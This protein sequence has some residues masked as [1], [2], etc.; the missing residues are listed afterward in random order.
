MTSPCDDS[1]RQQNGNQRKTHDPDHS[2]TVT[3]GP[4][5]CALRSF[6]ELIFFQLTTGIAWHLEPSRWDKGQLNLEFSKKLS[7]SSNDLPPVDLHSSNFRES[8]PETPRA[9]VCSPLHSVR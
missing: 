8:W 5:S 4:E 1:G 6:S 3:G 7:A 2:L 9:K